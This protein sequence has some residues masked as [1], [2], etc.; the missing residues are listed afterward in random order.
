MT[1]SYADAVCGGGQEA[2]AAGG[3]YFYRLEVYK[4][5][6]WLGTMNLDPDSSSGTFTFDSLSPGD[7]LGFRWWNN[8]FFPSNPG[9]DPDFTFTNIRLEYQ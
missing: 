4:N 9:K 8:H 6:T 5:G 2:L 3:A 1:L 7:T